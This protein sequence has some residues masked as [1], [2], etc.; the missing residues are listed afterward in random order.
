MGVGEQLKLADNIG[1][2]TAGIEDGVSVM[3]ES[4]WI[5][6]AVAQ[7]A[8]VALDDREEVVEI[9]GNAG[10]ESAQAF[11]LSVLL[12]AIVVGAPVI[13]AVGKNQE[14]TRR[15]ALGEIKRGEFG[16]DGFRGFLEHELDRSGDS[17][18]RL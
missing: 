17:L 18:G 1:A 13:A 5:G 2:T 10:G 7:E 14:A 11:E 8:G 15:A 9:V 4:G 12:G 6:C 3:A 16:Y